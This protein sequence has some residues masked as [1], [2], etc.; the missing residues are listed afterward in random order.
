[1]ISG[2]VLIG[3][4]VGSDVRNFY[5]KDFR[6]LVDNCGLDL[7]VDSSSEV[8]FGAGVRGGIETEYQEGV[9]LSVR[10]DGIC[11]NPREFE[12]YVRGN[13]AYAIGNASKRLSVSLMEMGRPTV[14]SNLCHREPRLDI[15]EQGRAASK[16][17]VKFLGNSSDGKRDTDYSSVAASFTLGNDKP[18]ILEFERYE[19][20]RLPAD[21]SKGF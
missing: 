18:R 14:G 9:L 21:Y 16:L 4:P 10:G 13:L 12:N 11:D 6:D 5:L 2:T 7:D 15:N 20:S 17:Y 1:M 8:V 19:P 3:R